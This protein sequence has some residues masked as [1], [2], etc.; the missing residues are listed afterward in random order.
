M[1]QK[2]PPLIKVTTILS[3][4]NVDEKKNWTALR[5]FSRW[6]ESKK[7]Q[8]LFAQANKMKPPRD[9]Q[10]RHLDLT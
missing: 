4:N 3:K 1:H 6:V 7:S 5:T 9:N 2:K 10:T 8:E